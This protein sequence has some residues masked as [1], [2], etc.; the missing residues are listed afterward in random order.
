[1]TLLST[2]WLQGG[3][4]RSSTV[5]MVVVRAMVTAMVGHQAFTTVQV[6][7]LVVAV[8]TLPITKRGTVREMKN[9]VQKQAQFGRLHVYAPSIVDTKGPEMK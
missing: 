3:K 4:A 2:I 7:V 9:G 6:M 1:M 8:G 5:A